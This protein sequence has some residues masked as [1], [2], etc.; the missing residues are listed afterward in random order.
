M[1]QEL[2]LIVMFLT[3]QHQFLLIRT[4][5]LSLLFLTNIQLQVSDQDGDALTYTIVDAPSNGTAVITET[6]AGGVLTYTSNTGF[7][8]NETFTYK[9]NDG[10]S[11]SNIG[12]ININVFE[13]ASALNWA[14]HYSGTERFNDSQRDDSGNI[15]TTGNFYDFSNFKDNTTLNAI[16]SRGSRDG[17]VAKYDENGELQWVNTFGGSYYDTGNSIKI[18]SNGDVI[19]SGQIIQVATF[20]DG[21]Q[22][23]TTDTNTNQR[24]QVILKLDGNTGDLLW[25]TYTGYDPD[26]NSQWAGGDNE[27][28]IK[29]DGTIISLVNEFNWNSDNTVK[30][31]EVN[32]SD[33]STNLVGEVPFTAHT[34]DIEI[35]NN[36][37][38]YMVGL[39]RRISM[40]TGF[41]Q[42]F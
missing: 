20:S 2:L 24:K 26:L 42:V 14:T 22:L 23:G 31:L 34:Y 39:D 11:D 21:E 15:Y 33:G 1:M 4:D 8:G 17:Y 38:I 3:I 19:V 13:K 5:Q 35:D 7:T 30:I 28:L 36:N 18:D 6:Q 29:N 10:T 40:V 25:K 37:N 32:S 27:I 16:Y 41:M 12:T 9:A